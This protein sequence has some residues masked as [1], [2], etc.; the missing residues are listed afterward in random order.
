MSEGLGT[1]SVAPVY[2]RRVAE[3]MCGAAVPKIRS[4]LGSLGGVWVGCVLLGWVA[5]EFRGVFG[6]WMSFGCTCTGFGVNLR[7]VQVSLGCH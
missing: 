4:R 7:W 1:V 3:C 6:V 2:S 5:I